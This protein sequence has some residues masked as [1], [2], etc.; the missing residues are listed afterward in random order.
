MGRGELDACRVARGCA[1]LRR[2]ERAASNSLRG[3]YR[4]FA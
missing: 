1:R 4:G 3:G 2:G